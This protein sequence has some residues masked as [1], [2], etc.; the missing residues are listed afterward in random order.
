[1]VAARI[2]R[3]YTLM[4]FR[5]PHLVYLVTAGHSLTHWIN[6]TCFLW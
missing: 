6:R 4:Q 1:M 3:D 5:C 2:I